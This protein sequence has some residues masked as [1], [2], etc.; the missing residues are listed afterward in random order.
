MDFLQGLTDHLIKNGVPPER[1]ES[2]A[3]DGELTTTMTFKEDG[4]ERTYIANFE[5]SSVRMDPNVLDALVLSWLQIY[6]PGR[7]G[8]KL[9]K[10]QFFCQ[11][12]DGGKYDIGYKIQFKET[13]KFVPSET[14]KW[15]I[16]GVKMSIET[17]YK[18]PES[19]GELLEFDAVTQ[20]TE[21]TN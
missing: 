13:C 12:L 6:D 14:G 8:K 2:W 21:L 20:D 9:D 15:D 16:G 19:F 17:N 7:D 5:M 3:E 11:P 4:F 18:E 10:P 1:L